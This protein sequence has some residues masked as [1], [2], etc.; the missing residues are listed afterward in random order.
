MIEVIPNTTIPMS[1]KNRNDTMNIVA[2]KPS[3]I[4]S[5]FFITFDF[6]ISR[7]NTHSN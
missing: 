5:L 7:I 2:K 3:I 1:P 4:V 6:S